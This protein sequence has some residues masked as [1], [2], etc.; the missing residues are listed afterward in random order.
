LH[1]V[2]EDH[3]AVL[4]E[5]RCPGV[6]ALHDAADGR[7]ARI[8]LPGGRLSPLALDTVAGLAADLGNGIVELT[9]RASLQVRGLDPGDAAAAGAVLRAAG[10]LPSPAHDRVRNI[11]ASPLAGCGPSS[12]AATDGVVAE[13]D[14]RLCATALLA[15]L[16]GRFLFAVDDGGVASGHERADVALVA[17]SPRSFR[18]VLAG[19]PTT[20]AAHGPYAAALAIDAAQAFLELVGDAWRIAE[21]PDGAR[22]IAEHLGG[23]LRDGEPLRP[24]RPLA[25]G[26]LP[27]RDGRVALTALPPLARLDSATAARLA[28]HGELRLSPARTVTLLDVPAARAGDVL[29]DLAALGLVTD[30][31][32]GWRG[33]TACA[34]LGACASARADVR[35]LAAAR[36]PE[37]GPDAPA[38]HWAA[39]ER[40][41]GRPPGALLRSGA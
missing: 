23:R 24:S 14:R 13:L 33:L 19:A 28:A 5:D 4:R 26:A 32:S 21:V 2:Q 17:E 8:R 27:Q 41:C 31:R 29:A 1:R 22:R 3:A 16:P 37:R 11:L 25:L 39:C 20:L 30:E 35:A 12:L 10:L 40:A 36:A 38:E 15:G 7:L 34:G 9:S 18:L 6:L